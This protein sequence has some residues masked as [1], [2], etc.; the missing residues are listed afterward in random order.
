MSSLILQNLKSDKQTGLAELFEHQRPHLRH[1]LRCRLNKV[2]SSRLDA[3]DVIQEVFIRAQKNVETYLEEPKVPPVIWLRQL[4]HHV[5]QD[6]HRRHF[7]QLR[8]PY[9][10]QQNCDDVLIANL[11]DSTDSVNTAYQRREIAES[12]RSLL[13]ELSEMDREVLELRHLEGYSISEI[14]AM[15]EL[16]SEA[17]KKRYYRALKRFRSIL[18][19]A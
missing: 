13:K 15:L 7:R 2:L 11:I 19:E 14:A 16:N 1:F 17:I 3:S 5:V 6:T 10:E 4:A 18:E 8:N 9:Q 12:L